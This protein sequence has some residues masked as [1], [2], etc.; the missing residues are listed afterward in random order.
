MRFLIELMIISQSGN[1]HGQSFTD[2]LNELQL[3]TNVKD[4]VRGFIYNADVSSQ[5]IV[6]WCES[7]DTEQSGDEV[8]ATE[9]LYRQLAE[10]FERF[11]NGVSMKLLPSECRDKCFEYVCKSLETLLKCSDKVRVLATNNNFVIAIVEQMEG[12]HSDMGGSFRELVRKSS[13]DKVSH[14]PAQ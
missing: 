14:I 8:Y 10:L 1:N 13:N 12:V 4:T 7:S 5:S 9:I 6:N 2:Q 11:S 3:S